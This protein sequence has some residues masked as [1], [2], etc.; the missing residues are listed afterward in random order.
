MILSRFD[1]SVFVVLLALAGALGLTILGGDRVGVQLTRFAPIDVARGASVVTLQFNEDMNRI[2]VAERFRLEPPIAGEVT[3]NGRTMTFRPRDGLQP[4]TRYAVTLEAGALSDAGR[5]VL[6]EHRFGFTVAGPR[7]AYLA[8]IDRAVQNIWIAEPSDAPNSH[9]LTHSA[10]G[11][12]SFDVNPDGGSLVFAE[13]NLSGGADLWQLDLMTQEQRVL[14]ACGDNLCTNPAWSPDGGRIA[15]E[16]RGSTPSAIPDVPRDVTRVWLLDLATAPRRAA[17]L[18][19]DPQIPRHFRPRWSPD[20]SRIAVSQPVASSSRGAGVLIHDFASGQTDFYPASSTAG[21]FSPDGASFAFT[22]LSPRDGEMR[23]V[24]RRAD[25]QV[26]EAAIIPTLDAPMESTE[27]GWG[28]AATA[29]AVARRYVEGSRSLGQQLYLVDAEDGAVRPLLV[30]ASYDHEFFSWDPSGR[31]LVLE[32]S[33]VR[34]PDP[35]ARADPRS[36]VWLYDTEQQALT[37]IAA[38]AHR[39]RWVP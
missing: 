10:L 3:W 16:R 39:P 9:Q 38:N 31:V 28:G 29:V 14:T 24:L 5:K 34:N 11:I 15:F 8:P 2:S 1:R 25:L 12:L 36:Q 30:D 35:S 37:L 18:F 19:D 6:G 27:I 33:L 17:P 22:A 7:I 21:A 13:Q 20:G 4:G 32:R 23:T 26:K